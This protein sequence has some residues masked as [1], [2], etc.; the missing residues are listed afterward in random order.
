[1]AAAS[2]KQ[3]D[4]EGHCL[5]EVSKLSFQ[6]ETTKD[7]I[8]IQKENKKALSQNLMN[9]TASRCI[10]ALMARERVFSEREVRRKQYLT[11]SRCTPTLMAREPTIFSP[12]REAEA[13]SERKV[14][15]SR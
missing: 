15:Q 11:A 12:T 3:Q 13:V 8:S 1:M 2:S 10:P 5:Q 14:H 4:H 6:K 7:G 9:L